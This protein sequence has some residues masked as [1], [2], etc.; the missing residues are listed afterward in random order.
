MAFTSRLLALLDL[1]DHRTEDPQRL[2]AAALLA[3]V[4]NADGRMRPQ[5]RERLVD[6]LSARFSLSGDDAADLMADAAALDADLDGATDL[7]DRIL[8]DT[9]TAD[10]PGLLVMAYQVA[11]ADGEVD[12]IE[13]SLVWRVGHLLGLSDRDI[14]AIRQRALAGGGLP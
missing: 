3:F 14:D 13:D 5:E 4:A 9:P 7:V 2:T 8:R 11:A 6:L 10:R 1:P 12:E